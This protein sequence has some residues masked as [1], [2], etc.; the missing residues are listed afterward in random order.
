MLNHKG[1]LVLVSHPQATHTTASGS[2]SSLEHVHAHRYMMMRTGV[3]VPSVIHSPRGLHNTG[4]VR[5]HHDIMVA[6]SFGKDNTTDT[7]Q[8]STEK[9]TLVDKLLFNVRACMRSCVQ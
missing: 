7:A 8:Q 1:L 5:Y 4:G 3:V 9:K 6:H 2:S